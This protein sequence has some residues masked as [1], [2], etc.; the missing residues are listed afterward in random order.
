[1]ISPLADQRL[2]LLGQSARPALR[3]ARRPSAICLLITFTRSDANLEAGFA[4]PR[5][6]RVAT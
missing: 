2:G 6:L 1:V 4:R 5:P 3:L